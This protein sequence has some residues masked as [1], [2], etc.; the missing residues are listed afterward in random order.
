MA[1]GLPSALSRLLDAQDAPARDE[2]WARFVSEHNRL[3]LHVAR[4]LNR[5][6]D[7]AM[8]AYAYVLEAL[9]QDGFRRLRAYSADRRSKFTT[10][11]VVVVR[12]LCLDHHRRRYGREQA[13]GAGP[14][15]EDRQTRR[16]LVDLVASEVD[17]AGLSAPAASRPDADLE[18]GE[19]R[20]SVQAALANLLPRDRLLLALRFEH[21]LS[22]REIAR[23]MGFP[24][25]F[26]VYRRLNA[27]LKGLRGSFLRR[28]IEGPEP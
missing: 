3:L 17:P 25:P 28:G 9:R 23:T 6:H 26:H 21:D 22:A 8:D 13:A 7:A 10:W 4:S 11:L 16:R 20:Q 24:T 27:L 18:A 1:D 12:R 19:L 14:D 2:A 15:E 5:E